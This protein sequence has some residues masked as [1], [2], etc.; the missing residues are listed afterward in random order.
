M[1]TVEFDTED[2]MHL[3]GDGNLTVDFL[4]Q[5][6]PMMGV[7]M[8][9]IDDESVVVEIFPNRPD[10]LSVEGFA[11][12]LSGFLGIETGFKNYQVIDPGIESNIKFHVNSNVKDVRAECACALIK[13]VELDDDS[14]VSL[15]NLQEKLHITHGRNRRKVAIGAHDMDRVKPPFKYLA[16]DPGGIR[17]VPLGM[18]EPMTP[19]EV[20][21]RH[22]KGIEYGDIIRGSP[23]YPL[24]V[25]SNSDVLSLPP[26]INGELTKITQDTK[27]IFLEVTGLDR[28]AVEKALNIMVTSIAER[29]GEIHGVEMIFEN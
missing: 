13:N 11:R 20:L 17:F 14:M 26:I 15:M 2:L 7:D 10:M 23:L 29:G 28:V 19:S 24:I 25:D 4:R 6:I 22:P 3:L 18:D 5:R 21:R 8:D 12:A 16:V 1:P 9:K 27:N